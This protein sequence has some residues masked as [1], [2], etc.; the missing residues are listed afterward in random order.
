MNRIEAISL[1]IQAL[2]SLGAHDGGEL[3]E[4]IDLIGD[5]I[6]DSLDSMMLIFELEKI[7]GRRISTID[8]DFSD[9]TVS[10]LA[11]ALTNDAASS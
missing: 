1:V 9:F 11:T 10:G 3:D 4:N 2:E 5:G 7:V 6:V 8:K